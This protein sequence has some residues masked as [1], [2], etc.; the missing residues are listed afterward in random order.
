MSAP[1]IKQESDAPET[2]SSTQVGSKCTE[3][4]LVNE[5][6]KFTLVDEPLELT[7]GLEGVTSHRKTSSP[8]SVTAQTSTQLLMGEERERLKHLSFN[9]PTSCHGASVY[10]AQERTHRRCLTPLDDLERW[11]CKL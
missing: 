4:S 6:Y 8:E 9:G 2:A 7:P 5:A 1:Q 11:L 3:N 10:T